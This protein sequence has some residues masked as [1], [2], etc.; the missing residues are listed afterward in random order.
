MIQRIALL[1]DDCQTIVPL[2]GFGDMVKIDGDVVGTVIGIAAYPHGIQFQVSWWHDGTLS[3]EWL[4]DWRLS[5]V[6]S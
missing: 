1:Y 3:S 5:K 2:Y 4:A 6:A